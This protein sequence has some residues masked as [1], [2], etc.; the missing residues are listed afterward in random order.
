VRTSLSGWTSVAFGIWPNVQVG[1]C[2]PYLRAFGFVSW[3]AVVG[4]SRRTR[5]S[6]LRPRLASGQL[7]D[8]GGKSGYGRLLPCVAVHGNHTKAVVAF[9]ENW[10]SPR[11]LGMDV[12]LLRDRMSAGYDRAISPTAMASAAVGAPSRLSLRVIPSSQHALIQAD[13]IRHFLYV[14]PRL[15]TAPDLA[16]P[17][18]LAC[19]GGLKL[20]RP[21]TAGMYWSSSA[22]SSRKASPRR[23]KRQWSPFAR[24]VQSRG[25][26]G[27]RGRASR[28][29]AEVLYD[30]AV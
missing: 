5:K 2:D 9:A 8:A 29:L 13:L 22:V 20:G 1:R 28:G 12:V 15:G 25:R 21:M 27:E 14:S 23:G 3:I 26:P 11:N 24:G 19:G 18:V 10:P 4:R 17:R 7:S 6:A 16:R 30:N